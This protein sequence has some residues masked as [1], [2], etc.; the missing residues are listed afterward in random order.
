MEA[1]QERE[2]VFV[3]AHHSLRTMNQPNAS[4][5]GFGDQGGSSLEPVHYGLGP[6]ETKTE[7]ETE[8]SPP[9]DSTTPPAPMETLRCLLLR[10]KSAIA[11]VNGHEHENRIEPFPRHGDNRNQAEGGFWEI[12]TA[13]HIDWPQQSRV[14]DLVNNLDGS[15]SIFTTML[16]HAAPPDPGAAPPSDGR[17]EAGS[18]TQRLASMAR[19]LSFNDLDARNGEDDEPAQRGD[20]RGSAEDR[21]TELV[22]KNPYA[23]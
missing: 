9:P 22:V 8:G 17:G 6:G 4:P 10:H 5:F 2:L 1:D 14:L 15:L 19:E 18:A 12:N 21:N 20:A 7:C 16:D 23:P 3:F 13:S 11:F